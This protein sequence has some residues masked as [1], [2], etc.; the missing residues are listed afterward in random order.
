M[1]GSAVVI[2][3]TSIVHPDVTLHDSVVIGPYCVIGS[4]H[5]PLRL[6]PGTIVRSHSVIEGGTVIG[7][8]LETGHHALIRTANEIGHNLRLGSYSSIE[9][10]AAIGDYVRIHGRSEV[11]RADIRHFARI[12]ANS[13]VTDNRLPPSSVQVTTVMDEGSVITIGCVLV[14]GVRLGIGSFVGAGTTVTRDVPDGMAL[15]GSRVVPVTSLRW[16]GY[17]Y[18]WT[19]Y[20]REDYEPEA[21]PRI[22]ELHRRIME[23]LA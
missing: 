9:G 13:Y 23:A 8:R 15:V 7:D 22:D 3:P 10:H 21:W 16:K 18:P 17:S 12:Y 2:H 4:D 11:P 5:G 1:E 14:A 20:Y 6:G 19:G